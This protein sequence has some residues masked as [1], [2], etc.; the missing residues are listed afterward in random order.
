M[1]DTLL[2]G[3]SAMKLKFFYH[4]YQFGCLFHYINM[5][6]KDI[7]MTSEIT[8]TFLRHLVENEK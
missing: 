2:K 1:Y 7:N 5:L 4:K 6:L 8:G 3:E